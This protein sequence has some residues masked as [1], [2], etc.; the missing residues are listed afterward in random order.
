MTTSD[1]D[2][3]K[4]TPIGNHVLRIKDV[5]HSWIDPN[6]WVYSNNP[7]FEGDV[8]NFFGWVSQHGGNFNDIEIVEKT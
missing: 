5:F 6:T 3:K 1:L 2:S 8:S 7:C 4:S